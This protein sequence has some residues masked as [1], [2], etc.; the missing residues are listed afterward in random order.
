MLFTRNRLLFDNCLV[1]QYEFGTPM[2]YDMSLLSV[3]N[4]RLV[5]F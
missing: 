3:T 2:K 5:S 1:I 4:I